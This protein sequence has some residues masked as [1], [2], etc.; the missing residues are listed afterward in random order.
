MHIDTVLFK[1]LFRD[2]ILGNIHI[3]MHVLIAV[4]AGRFD[5]AFAAHH[6]TIARA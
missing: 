2:Y 5:D 1:A 6:E 4:H 3:E